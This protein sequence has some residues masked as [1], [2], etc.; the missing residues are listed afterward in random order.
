MPAAGVKVIVGAATLRV[1]VCPIVNGPLPVLLSM[2]DTFTLK[3][4][5]CRVVPVMA[6]PLVEKAPSVKPEGKLVAARPFNGRA[7]P[8]QVK[9][10]LYGAF[11]GGSNTAQGLIEVVGLLT[12][13][14]TV[15]GADVP[16]E[17]VA[18]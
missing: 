14:L 6:A 15:A 1:N 5:T 11:R 12:V 8:F 16:P 9:V 10:Q 3:L 2:A 18:V 7:P 13:M 17:L 4:P